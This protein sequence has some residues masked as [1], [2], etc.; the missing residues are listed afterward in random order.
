LGTIVLG[1]TPDPEK[2]LH[3]L[4]TSSFPNVLLEEMEEAVGY[5]SSK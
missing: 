5:N 4:F 1:D 2:G 3:P